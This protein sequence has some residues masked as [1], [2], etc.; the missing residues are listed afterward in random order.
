[1]VRGSAMNFTREET[2]R[3]IEFGKKDLIAVQ[4][5]HNVLNVAFYLGSLVSD[6]RAGIVARDAGYVGQA[7]NF[8][9]CKAEEVQGMSLALLHTQGAP[10]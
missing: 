1:M 4:V 5:V 2:A 10:P 8:I 7:Q 6:Q 9:T 3:M